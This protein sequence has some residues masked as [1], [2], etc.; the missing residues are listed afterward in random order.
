MNYKPAVRNVQELIEDYV[1]DFGVTFED[2]ERITLVVRRTSVISFEK[3]GGDEGRGIF[4]YPSLSNSFPT[5]I[6][7]LFPL[8]RWE[9]LLVRQDCSLHLEKVEPTFRGH[10]CIYCASG[11]CPQERRPLQG[12]GSKIF[13]RITPG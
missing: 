13:K 10:Y 7:G 4:A 12:T 1:R 9:N 5:S 8:K 3:H 2:A 6:L 11:E